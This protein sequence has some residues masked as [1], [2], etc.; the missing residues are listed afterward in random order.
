[1]DNILNLLSENEKK[2]NEVIKNEKMIT[3]LQ[4]ENRK[5]INEVKLNNEEIKKACSNINICNDKY[6]NGKI[7]KL[8]VVGDELEYI[9]KSTT[10]ALNDIPKK[11]SETV[12]LLQEYPCR[13]KLELKQRQDFYNENYKNMKK[14]KDEKDAEKK[15]K[16]MK[17]FVEKY[18]KKTKNNK[19]CIT[20]KIIHD[21]FLEFCEDNKIQCGSKTELISYLL[22]NGYELKEQN[23]IDMFFN[24]V[25]HYENSLK[26]FVNKCVVKTNNRKNHITKKAI[27]EKYMTFC[28]ENSYRCSPRKELL[29]YLQD[30]GYETRILNGYEIYSNIKCTLPA[31]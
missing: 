28:E 23:G 16:S 2:I 21:K 17:L 13:N 9:I 31:I 1:M 18:V 3:K 11:S 6:L 24:V 12:E 29:T 20:K 14:I 26:L 15:S 19:D 25:C 27:F 30:A 7:Y 10:M 22:K 8:S 5:M 4:S